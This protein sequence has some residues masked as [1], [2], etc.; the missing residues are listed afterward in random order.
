MSDT[1]P[2]M[3]CGGACGRVCK[4]L[5]FKSSDGRGSVPPPV[6]SSA[7]KAAKPLVQGVETEKNAASKPLVAQRQAQGLGAGVTPRPSEA[8]KKRAPRGTFDRNAYQRELMRKRR[9]KK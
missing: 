5:G 3:F 4:G 2:C 6:K 7:E 9:A 1:K 8:K